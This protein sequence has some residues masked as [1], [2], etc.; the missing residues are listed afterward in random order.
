MHWGNI[1]SMLGGLAALI[2]AAVTLPQIPGGVRDWR[3]RQQEQRDLA[4]DEREQIALDRRRHLY[5]WSAHGIDTF[6]VTLVTAAE[7]LADALGRPDGL[8]DYVVL[9]VSERGEGNANRAYSLRQ[10]IKTEG[11]ISR[12]PTP[13]EREA[14]EAGLEAMGI[15]HAAY[16]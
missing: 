3:K 9:R 16:G 14:L 6:G 15:A 4:A 5:G 2:V 1:G 7:E 13:G 8:G 10:V 12:P 11:Y